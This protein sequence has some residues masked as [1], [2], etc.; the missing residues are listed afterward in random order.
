MNKQTG[1]DLISIIRSV[2]Q[3]QKALTYENYED[4]YKLA[5]FHHVE[6]IS[7]LGVKDQKDI[8]FL[9]KWKKVYDVTNV[10]NI[11]FEVERETILKEMKKHGLSYMPLKGINLLPCY[12]D[13]GMRMMSDNDILYGFVETKEG[14]YYLNKDR[15]QEAQT[16][17]VQIME[18]LGYDIFSLKG[19]DD[20]FHKKPFYNFEMHRRLTASGHLHEEYYDNP[21][22]YAIQDKEDLNL[23][24][25][26]KEEEY[27]YIIEHAYKHYKY[28]GVGIR[29]LIDMYVY[30]RRYRNIMD[31][32][33]I[34]NQIDKLKMRDFYHKSYK[35]CINAFEYE[36]DKDDEEFLDFLLSCGIYGTDQQQMNNRLEGKNK[37]KYIINRMFIDKNE[38]KDQYPFFYK[39]KIFL[40]LLPFYRLTL[41]MIRSPKRIIK[42][43]KM[44][45]RK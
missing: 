25:L 24:Y 10:R 30:L 7:Y 21:F 26:S 36:M 44:L 43:I 35:L 37:L 20:V 34:L 4:I 41:A 39:H 14:N 19:K 27:I 15:E 16:R 40:P 2:L 18:N 28:A 12:E 8:P 17:L 6:G 29:Y 13:Y 42:E 3:N 38:C 22:D 1:L 11:Y 45:I 5:K 31:F 23:Y 32:T 33:Y 9:D